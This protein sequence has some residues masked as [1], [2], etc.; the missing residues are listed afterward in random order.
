M[1]RLAACVALW[2]S[3]AAAQQPPGLE[4]LERYFLCADRYALRYVA[5]PAA[6][7]DIGD[8][9]LAMCESSLLSALAAI[10]IADQQRVRALAIDAR[11]MARGRAIAFVLG[12]RYPSAPK[13]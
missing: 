4:G 11:A 7:S 6:P 9:A 2:A 8:A 12:A 13:M 1:R 5:T 3:Q 10:E